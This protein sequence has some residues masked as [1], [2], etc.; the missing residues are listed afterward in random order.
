MEIQSAGRIQ[1][2]GVCYPLTIR[3]QENM[4]REDMKTDSATTRIP[5]CILKFHLL[6]RRELMTTIIRLISHAVSG[7]E[8]D[9]PTGQAMEGAITERIDEFTGTMKDLKQMTQ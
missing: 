4:N 5:S 3:D 9:Q 8:Q 7:L 1:K 2:Q 6:A